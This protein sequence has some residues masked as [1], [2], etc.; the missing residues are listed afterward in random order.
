MVGR[1]GGGGSEGGRKASGQAGG[2]GEGRKVGGRKGGRKGGRE[3][4]RMGDLTFPAVHLLSGNL[5]KLQCR[6]SL[7]LLYR[8]GGGLEIV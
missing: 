2:Q 5:F 4:G 3:G 7:T 6:P 1:E 8:D